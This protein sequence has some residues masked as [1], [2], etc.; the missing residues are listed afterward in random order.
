VH[1]LPCFGDKQL[2][3]IQTEAVQQFISTLKVGPSCV[4][5]ILSILKAVWKTGRAWGYV[6]HDPFD[7]LMLPKLHR[8]ESRCFS[9]E[10][11]RK[12]IEAA[13]EPWRT[14]Y[15]LAA[16]TGLRIGELLGLAWADVDLEKGVLSVR[17]SVWNGKLQSTKSAAADR[18]FPLS[19]KLLKHLVTYR[20]NYWRANDLDLLFANARGK[21]CR[22]S[23][24]RAKILQP[25]LERLGIP[26]AGFHAFRQANATLLDRMN[27][28]MKI[29]QQRL[30]HTQAEMTL[31]I[32]T[33]VVDEDAREVAERFDKYLAPSCP[34]P[35]IAV[36]TEGV[37]P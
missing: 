36:E 35:E 17:T 5:N 11:V 20:Q 19:S 9:Q 33:H 10:D 15:W 28:P 13:A 31:S 26:R 4:R 29:R 16:Q 18:T 21:P 27:S 24:I 30:G 1:V 7:G 6:R 14:L 23:R 34:N 8:V 22:D 3:N 32:Y 12:I 2:E 25:L 37:N